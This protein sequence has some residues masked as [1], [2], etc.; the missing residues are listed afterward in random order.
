MLQLSVSMRSIETLDLC[1]TERLAGGRSEWDTF[2]G[3]TGEGG[4]LSCSRQ[5]E[6]QRGKVRAMVKVGTIRFGDKGGS[7][8]VEYRSVEGTCHEC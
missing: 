8:L 2:E 3:T 5:A 1:G 4:G 7:V 6:G